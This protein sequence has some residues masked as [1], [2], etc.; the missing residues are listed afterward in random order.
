MSKKISDIKVHKIL[1]L[2]ADGNS[3]HDVSKLTDVSQTQVRRI[4]KKNNMNIRQV[5]TS[6]DIER[7]ICALYDSEES[8]EKLPHIC[9]KS[10]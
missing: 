6:K 3:T 9:N 5:K 10:I 8:S 4:L 2:Y 7:Q 1:T